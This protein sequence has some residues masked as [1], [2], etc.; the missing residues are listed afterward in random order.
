MKNG[1]F[2]VVL[3]LVCTSC[4]SLHRRSEI[5]ELNDIFQICPNQRLFMYAGQRGR[6]ITKENISLTKAALYERNDTLFAEFIAA[7]L[8]KPD[9]NPRT[10][11]QSDSSA[12]LFVHYNPVLNRIKEESP[13]FNYQLKSFDVDLFTVPFK[14]RFRQGERPGQLNTNPNAGVYIGVRYD[15]GN[16]RTLFFRGQRESQRRS[17]SFGLGGFASVGSTLVSS[18]TTNGRITEEYEALGFNYGLALILGYKTFTAGLALG[19]E[20]LANNHNPLWIYRNK[21]YLG[22]TIGLNLN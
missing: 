17:F 10:L 12:I 22:V 13:W 5:L 2:L 7:S 1:L 8:P 3:G 11:D 14:Y 16:Y 20:N 21:S 15:R 9:N 6:V 18:F 19:F 4:A